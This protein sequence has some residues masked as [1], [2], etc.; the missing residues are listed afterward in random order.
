MMWLSCEPIF[1]KMN[2]ES[3][4]AM[5]SLSN[6]CVSLSIKRFWALLSS[7]KRVAMLSS[8]RSW[9]MWRSVS[10]ADL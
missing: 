1:S 7:L 8:R 5:S 9:F 10:I 4:S 3:E 6:D 2:G